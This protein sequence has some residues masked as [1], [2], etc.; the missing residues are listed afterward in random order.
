[1]RI[2]HVLVT[3][4][5][6]GTE[7][8]VCDVARESAALGHDVTVVG[9]DP[10]LVPQHA[11]NAVRWLPGAS[12]KQA[13]H[14]LLQV[15]PLDVVHTHLTAADVVGA[16]VRR[17][18]GVRLVSTRHI[19]APRGSSLVGAL[20]RPALRHEVDHQLAISDFVARAAD[21][22]CAV[23]H[24]GVVSRQTQPDPDSR[25]VLVC[26]RLQREKDTALAV[27][28]FARSSLPHHGWHLHV[29]GQGSERGALEDLVQQLGVGDT[30]E[31]LGFVSDVELLMRGAAVLLATAP[32]EPLGLTVLEAMAHG[33]PVVAA[34]GGGHLET[35]GRVEGASLFTPGD[36]AS[37]AA[38]LDEIAGDAVAARAYGE[39]CRT[40]QQRH[41]QLQDHVRRVLAEYCR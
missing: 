29:A 34:A 23:V 35:V 37:C 11:G 2:A 8:Y 26:Q 19:A 16:V 20:L 36:E 22:V 40:V 31:L 10:L 17:L 33:L 30:V 39:R 5:F 38:A 3:G 18:H 15:Q 4:T 7:R 9:G 1:M 6:A 24:N 14:S 12:L 41:F 25:I 28:A 27:R 13:L 21:G 32:E